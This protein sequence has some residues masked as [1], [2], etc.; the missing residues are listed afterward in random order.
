MPP[1]D[2]RVGRGTVAVVTVVE[3]TAE[4]QFIRRIGVLW[5]SPARGS[6]FPAFQST[7]TWNDS[8]PAWTPTETERTRIA[9]LLD[10]AAAGRPVRASFRAG[11][12]ERYRGL[13]IADPAAPW[14]EPLDP[15]RFDHSR[16]PPAGPEPGT[17]AAV[18]PLFHVFQGT[19]HRWNGDGTTVAWRDAGAEIEA[20]L[21]A[22]AIAA[23][24]GPLLSALGAGRARHLRM[25]VPRR[26]TASGQLG[27]GLSAG[28]SPRSSGSTDLSHWT[29]SDQSSSRSAPQ[30][31]A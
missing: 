4:Q 24:E 8:I 27:S 31:S 5:S 7:S 21:M 14:P 6:F 3:L 18:R 29:A 11:S 20:A 28:G 2:L 9:E 26:G 17:A 23:G 25:D 1:L 16:T 13:I 12:V 30:R 19:L 22:S 15:G 10:L